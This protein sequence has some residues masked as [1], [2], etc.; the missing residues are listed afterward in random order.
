MAIKVPDG[1]YNDKL[2]KI[3]MSLH[4]YDMVFFSEVV[5]GTQQ[6][7]EPDPLS[8]IFLCQTQFSFENR[9]VAGNP[10]YGVLPDISGKPKVL[11]N[12]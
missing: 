6:L 9:W 7:P 3:M 5:G 4:Q 12:I 11:G 2:L 1:A 8:G 10:K